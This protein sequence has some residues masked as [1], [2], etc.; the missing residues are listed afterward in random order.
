VHVSV[1][2]HSDFSGNSDNEIFDNDSDSD[3][4]IPTSSLRKHLGPSAV[5][6][7]SD[8]KKQAQKRKKIVNQRALMIR[9]VTCGVKII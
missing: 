2:T 3:I 1:D 6:F 4:D 8:C 9:Q 7:N 5:V